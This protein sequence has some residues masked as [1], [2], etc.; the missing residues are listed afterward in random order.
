MS[1]QDCEELIQVFMRFYRSHKRAAQV[2]MTKYLQNRRHE[3]YF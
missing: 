2:F 3:K 1:Q